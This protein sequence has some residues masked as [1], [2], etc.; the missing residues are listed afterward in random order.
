M[1]ELETIVIVCP[2]DVGR[3]WIINSRD[4]DPARHR[5]WAGAPTLEQGQLP[6]QDAES[7]AVTPGNASRPAR[8]GKRTRS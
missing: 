7:D 2:K 5:A 3:Y 6:E 4:F 1:A 8:T